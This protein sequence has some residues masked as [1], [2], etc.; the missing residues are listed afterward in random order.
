MPV[1]Y[2]LALLWIPSQVSGF[3]GSVLELVGTLSVYCDWVRENFL[4]N[5]YLSVARRT[6]A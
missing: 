3:A 2:R 5:F 6:L 4:C 1:P